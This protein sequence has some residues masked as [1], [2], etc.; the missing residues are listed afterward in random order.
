MYSKF[1][2]WIYIQFFSI[3]N[4]V[5]TLYSINSLIIASLNKTIHYNSIE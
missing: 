2:V 4:N 3:V 1:I 5:Q